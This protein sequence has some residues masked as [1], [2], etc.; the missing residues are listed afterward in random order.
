M[1]VAKIE[2]RRSRA[3]HEVQALIEAVYQAQREALKVPED[4]R[5]IRYIEHRPEHFAVPPGRSENY[6]FVEILLFPGRSLDAKRR[7]Y[8]SIVRRFGEL[9][10]APHDVFIVLQEPALENW[11]IRGGQAAVDVELGF[12]LKV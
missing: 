7:L 10:I 12:E 3:P 8:A 1:P 11:G 5:Q 9:G 4:D 2:V 6:T